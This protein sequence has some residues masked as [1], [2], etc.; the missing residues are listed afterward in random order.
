VFIITLTRLNGARMVA[1][2]VVEVWRHP[3]KSL[4]GER[5]GEAVIEDSGMESDRRW[6]IVDRE[7]G[8]VLTA[9]RVP[10]LLLARARLTEAGVDVVLPDGD[11]LAAPSAHT[12]DVLSK[13]LGRDVALVHAESLAS[14]VGE[15][16]QNA[17]DEE[18]AIVSWTMPP[19]R[20]VDALPL[21]ILTTASLRAGRA[22]HPEGAWDARRFR[23]N[24]VIDVDDDGWVED[25]WCG[26]A[27]RIG[28]AVVQ[29]VVPCE[30]CT[31]VTRAQPELERDL[32]IFKTLARNHGKNVG[33]WTNVQTPGVLHV[34]DEVTLTD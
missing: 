1:M 8:N 24:I 30:R 6:G 19:G 34:G 29:P 17:I 23:P 11:V 16:F 25:A 4:Q 3:V 14:G 15:Y 10:A 20:F 9:K 22:L 33:V 31:M 7:S 32:D 21:L 18:S 13:W 26:H 12:D 28:T 27:L 2:R 5:L